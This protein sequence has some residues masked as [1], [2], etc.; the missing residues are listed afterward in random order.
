MTY[1]EYISGSYAWRKK[2][3]ERLKIDG[4]KCVRCGISGVRLEIHHKT[5]ERL[6]NEHMDDLETLCVPCHDVETNNSRK[7]KYSKRVHKPITYINQKPNYNG[8]FEGK[9]YVSIPPFD[10]QRTDCRPTKPVFK[11]YE[12]DFWK[13]KKDRC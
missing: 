9:A 5:Y 7:E 10:A 6:F 1:Q 8:E 13:T 4:N 3:E 11:G 12:G 2:R